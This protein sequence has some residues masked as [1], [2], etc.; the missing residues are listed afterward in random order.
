[1][2]RVSKTRSAA[3]SGTDDG[4][5]QKKTVTVVAY[6]ANEAFKS[7][8]AMADALDGSRDYYERAYNRSETVALA[9]DDGETTRDIRV[10]GDKVKEALKE[11]E[12]DHEHLDVDVEETVSRPYRYSPDQYVDEVRRGLCSE[13]PGALDGDISTGLWNYKWQNDDMETLVHIRKSGV[14]YRRV[15]VHRSER[16][17]R[18][19]YDSKRKH[20][21]VAF[22]VEFGPASTDLVEEWSETVVPVM[23]RELYDLEWVEK[24][25]IADCVENV[26]RKGDCFDVA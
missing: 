22:T 13:L 5:Q 17:G 23:I 14:D 15:L 8:R 16:D 11:A 20:L 21:S 2:V 10:Y 4:G 25:R 26:E 1:M 19:K 18:R 24:V 3:D 7:E 12:I 9:F 6:A